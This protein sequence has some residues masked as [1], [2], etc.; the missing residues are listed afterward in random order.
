MNQIPLDD[1]F[2][3]GGAPV[4]A[5]LDGT[6]TFSSFSGPPMA[7]TLQSYVS[8]APQVALVRMAKPISDDI[9]S[10]VQIGTQL[11]LSDSISW[12]AAVGRSRAGKVPVRGLGSNLAFQENHAAGATWTY[13]NGIDYPVGSGSGAV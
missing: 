13:S 2:W 12:G 5:A 3:Q 10:T 6:Y 7:A 1:R 4:F 9:G 8:D 11:A